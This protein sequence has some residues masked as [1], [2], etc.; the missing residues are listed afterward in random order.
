MPSQTFR[1]TSPPD[2]AINARCPR[3]STTLDT[4][5]HA[6]P[7]CGLGF[8]ARNEPCQKC[9]EPLGSHVFKCPTT[10][11]TILCPLC[12]GKRHWKDKS[13]V[14]ECAYRQWARDAGRLDNPADP[15]DRGPEPT[16]KLEGEYQRWLAERPNL[17][18]GSTPAERLIR[19]AMRT[20]AK[21]A[22]VYTR[23]TGR[24]RRT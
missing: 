21:P 22:V 16:P 1:A 18:A 9:N 11:V 7:N 13:S 15:L 14:R 3:C 4:L 12:G 24:L 19:Q 23:P 10:R 20:A 2:I 8:L 5:T 6:C 17:L